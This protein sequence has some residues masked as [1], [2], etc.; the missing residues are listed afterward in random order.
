MKLLWFFGAAFLLSAMG[1]VT[2][3]LAANPQAATQQL[4]DGQHDFDFELGRWNIHLKRRLH[5]LTGSAVWVEFDG[6]S[7]TRKVWEGRSQLEE[8][9]TDSG[10]SGHIEGLTLRL[11]NPQ[12]HQWSL[13]WANAKDGIVVPAQIGEFKNGSGEFFGQDTLNG[14]SILIRFVWSNTNTGMPHFEQSFSDDG[15]KSWEVN[16]ITDQ[17]RVPDESADA[18]PAPTIAQTDPRA[19]S[20]KNEERDGQHDFD[21]NIGIW[22]THV[23]RL[24][25]PLTG[26]SDWTEMNGTVAVRK[27]WDGRAELE[28]IEADGSTG[29]FE[30]LTL[31]LYNPQSHQWTQS[32]ANSSDGAMNTPAIGEFKN[33]RG[34]FLDQEMYKGRAILVR[35]VWSDITPNS[36]HFEQSF[37]SD[38]GK[39]WEPNFVAS[40]TR[41]EE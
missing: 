32:F 2:D 22:K 13:Y 37:S 15:G 14:K 26:S 23:M 29:H 30:G 17:T 3:P 33:G 16:W 4:R 21:F 39:T 31:F 11:Y 18:S 9:E 10:A 41:K 24:Q 6:T 5:P 28:E 40:L 25:H 19:E 34:E 8:F 20:A 7:V 36:H 35:I 38:G 27:V 1:M 12:S